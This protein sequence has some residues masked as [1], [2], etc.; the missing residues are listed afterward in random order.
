MGRLEVPMAHEVRRPDLRSSSLCSDAESGP[1]KAESDLH[2]LKR[3]LFCHFLV[4][5][6]PSKK[7]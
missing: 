7:K 1:F 3:C 2:G 4:R 5:I 6:R